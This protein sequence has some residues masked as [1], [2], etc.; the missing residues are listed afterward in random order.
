MT[1]HEVQNII[2]YSVFYGQFRIYIPCI[3]N[4]FI[5]TVFC[6]TIGFLWKW[7]LKIFSLFLIWH[8]SK[9]Q[10]TWHGRRTETRRVLFSLK[11]LLGCILLTARRWPSLAVLN[12]PIVH[13]CQFSS[14]LLC[15]GGKPRKCITLSCIILYSLFY[16][17]FCTSHFKR[18]YQH[19]IQP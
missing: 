8:W 16:G 11:S 13:F 14:L 2:L 12:C 4:A 7:T 3:L 17:Q 9:G 18:L 6:Q 5:D 1:V 19:C 10:L 15:I